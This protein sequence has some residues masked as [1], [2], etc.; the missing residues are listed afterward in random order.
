MKLFTF[1]T[2]NSDLS[3]VI[4]GEYDFL[5]ILFSY[6]IAVV[7]SYAAFSVS[8]TLKYI[9]KKS[10]KYKWLILGSFSMGLGVWAMHFIGMLAYKLPLNVN[11]SLSITLFS[12]IP[13]I[14]SSALTLIIISRSSITRK[15]LIVGG[16]LLGGGIGLMH[17]TGMMAMQINAVMMYDPLLF[18]LSIIFAVM[19]AIIALHTRFSK[20][21][22][23]YIKNKFTLKLISAMI[24]GL[25]I[26]AMHYTGM[27]AV[28]FLPNGVDHLQLNNI[29]NLFLAGSVGFISLLIVVFTIIVSYIHNR[30]KVH[31]KSLGLKVKTTTGVGVLILLSMFILGFKTYQQG[32]SS[33][34]QGALKYEENNIGIIATSIEAALNI[35]RNNLMVIRD[36]PPVRAIIKANDNGGIDPESGNKIEV[37]SHRLELILSAFLNNH[38]QYIQIRYINESGQELVRVNKNHNIIITPG[39]KLQNKS[40]HKYFIETMKLAENEIYHSDVTLNRENG[41]IQT[42]HMPVLRLA[43][44]VYYNGNVR[45]MVIINLSTE[46]LFKLIKSDDRDNFHYLTNENGYYLKHKDN[47]KTFSFELDTKFNLSKE[48]PFISRT[49]EINHRFFH[50]NNKRHYIEGF[51]KIYFD[52]KVNNRYWILGF[53]I[54]E[55]E[56]F[57]ELNYATVELLYFGTIV[58]I[59]SFVFIIMFFS[60][61]I[62]N[63]LMLLA[64][65]AEKLRDGDLTTRLPQHKMDDEFSILAKIINEFAQVQEQSNKNFEIQIVQRTVELI[66]AKE[67]AEKASRS[68]SEFLANMSHEIRTPMNGVLGMLELLQATSLDDKQNNFTNTARESALSLLEIINDILDFSKI[69]AGQL[70]LENVSFNIHKTI[71]DVAISLA[72]LASNKNI[73]LNCYVPTEIP[74]YVSGDPL[75]LRQVVTNLASNAIKFT[76]SGE[77]NI[78]VEITSET[79][80][81]LCLKFSIQDTGI[82]ISDD[83]QKLLFEA[84]NQVDGSTTRK[85]GGTGLGLSISKQIVKK[86]Q[87]EINVNS[88]LDQGSTFWFTACFDH[89]EQSLNTPK[90]HLQDNLRVL[91]VDENATNREIQTHYLTSWN[92]T[93]Q[94]ADNAETALS[95]MHD[96]ASDSQHFHVV[97]LDYH[98]PETDG[99]ALAKMI[100]QD[101]H[102]S[103]CH[104]IILTSVSDAD[105]KLHD[106]DIECILYKPARQ[107]DIYDALLQ[108]T[109]LI[110]KNTNVEDTQLEKSLLLRNGKSRV[111]LVDDMST[112]QFVAMEILRKFELTPDVAS[113][114]QEA[115]DA[116]KLNTYD[117][118]LMDCQMPIMDG[119]AATE[120]IRAKEKAQHTERLPI[121]ALTANAMQGDKE[122]CIAAGMDDYLAKPFTVNE[123]HK[124]LDRWLP[125]KTILL[126]ADE[127][128]ITL[129]SNA[130]TSQDIFIDETQTPALDPEKLKELINITGEHFSLLVEGFKADTASVFPNLRIAESENNAVDIR[131]SAHA[132]KGISVNI[133]AVTMS[134][135]CKTLEDQAR[136]N[137]IVDLKKQIRMIEEEYERIIV[138]L[139]ALV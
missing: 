11:Y 77:V 131:F 71:E 94:S 59:V 82:G 115:I 102:I 74:V 135:L 12:V 28:Y 20:L 63:P 109:G 88:E 13:A 80:Q 3:Q 40:A 32:I 73:E 111:L 43:T 49:S 124:I 56:F 66:E 104:L 137:N 44:P 138:E 118:V 95:L 116:I 106:S 79:K 123:L 18:T 136:D 29:S 50:Y 72:S 2:E 132:L 76:E 126:E 19:L 24:M 78:Y 60:R 37:W 90:V 117:L 10:A 98:M 113:N 67:I 68:K 89:T 70:H 15:Q 101:K 103:D 45:G 14:L 22:N 128:K 30:I 75:R 119:Y 23:Q 91:I 48:D 92:I 53:N 58:G 129:F 7:S 17:Y 25:A 121:I 54:Q 107:S 83:N 120:I 125:D 1:I 96:A 41:V 36:T 133:S 55:G 105:K 9:E 16:V 52:P 35:D 81:Q 69:E 42:P 47:S 112:N 110:D 62:I 86:M 130:E 5:L 134:Q 8:S 46:Y 65:S 33:A 139:D 26:T 87:G 100:K 27:S 93:N 31:K 84:F 51:R 64:N 85:Y 57:T 34:I 21:T 6:S 127:S 114:G 38:Q 108:V 4:T 122:N 39:N 97:I 61:T 99:L